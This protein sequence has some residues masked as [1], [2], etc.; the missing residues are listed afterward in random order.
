[1]KLSK[2][3]PFGK[4][5]KL[6]AKDINPVTTVKSFALPAGYLVGSGADGRL[7]ARQA[8]SYYDRAGPVAIAVDWVNDEFKNL[9]LV[10]RLP[11][12][13]IIKDDPLLEFLMQ[14][15]DDMTQEDF[16]ENYGASYLLTNESYVIAT[17]DVNREPAELLPVS[18]EDVTTYKGSDGFISRMDV[19]FNGLQLEVFNRDSLQYRFFNADRTREIWQVKGF[20]ARGNDYANGG[21]SGGVAGNRG[22]SKLLSIQ[23]EIEQY[24]AIATNNLS[25]LDKGMRPSGSLEAPDTVSEEQ[26]ER[27]KEQVVRFYSNAANAGN[28]LILDNGMKFVPLST[29]AKDM[30]FK[31]LTK[32]VTMTV[33]NRYK[34]PL[35]LVT[36]DNMTLNNLETAKLNLYDNAVLPL[37]ARLLREL[38][39]FMSFRFDIPEGAILAPDLDQ[40]TALQ[41]RRNEELKLKSDLNALTPNEIREEISRDRVEGGDVVYI[42]NN[43][44]PIGT[45]PVEPIQPTTDVTASDKTKLERKQF[46]DLM[47]NQKD[48]DGKDL[49]TKEQL[50]QI[51]DDEGLI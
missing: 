18:P 19:R 44:V 37:A 27:L 42:P 17:G 34:V 12:G 11:D 1:M 50:L 47:Q 6:N 3:N 31:E 43:L 8:L 30:D 13:K 22:R 39:N 40:V 28:V 26:F 23:R 29:A 4:S 5:E 38:T 48:A 16:L 35:P 41:L 49:Y 2:L 14:P 33:F 10:L 46:F 24:I 51:A 9:N 15:N 32:Q 25:I 20:S 45:T 21:F 36:P 7:S